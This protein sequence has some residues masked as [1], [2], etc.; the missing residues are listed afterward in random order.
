MNTTNGI[1][2]FLKPGI[3][4]ALSTSVEGGVTY[5]REDL[6]KQKEGEGEAAEWR[7]TR[8]ITD[9]A[10]YNRAGETRAQARACI[11]AVCQQTPWGLICETDREGELLEA[12]A[13]AEQMADT[14]N[15]G[16]VHSRVRISAAPAR[17]AENDVQMLRAVRREA[18]GMLE[19]L[20]RATQLGQVERIRDL[21]ARASRLKALLASQHEGT[22]QLE[23]A[24]AAARA[25]ARSVVKRVEKGGEALAAVLA[26][27]NFRPISTARMAMA[28]AAAE[29]AEA[30]PLTPSG[31]ALPGVA[32]ARFSNL[33]GAAPVEVQFEK[34]ADGEQGEAA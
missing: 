10:E 15:A 27:A 33:S 26:S 4:L 22:G 18:G 29:A 5:A 14:F 12:I 13:E 2:P 19:D 24:I 25:V 23:R 32:L 28:K 3:L 6:G 34:N 16:S 8:H 20:E 30:R 31:G 11:A 21:A 1:A 7:T 17:F 9:V